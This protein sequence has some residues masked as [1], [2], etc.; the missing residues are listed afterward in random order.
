[1]GYGDNGDGGGVPTGTGDP[2]IPQG[3]KN[4]ALRRT[5]TEVTYA[6]ARAAGD[7]NVSSGVWMTRLR[8]VLQ[9]WKSFYLHF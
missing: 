4:S 8:V 9:G 1:M 3:P 7:G 5:G 2:D 6:G